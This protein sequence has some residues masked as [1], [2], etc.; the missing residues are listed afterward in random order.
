MVITAD[1]SS[2]LLRI[3]GF[4]VLRQGQYISL[5]G[6]EFV[7]A[8]V[9]SGVRYLTT[10]VML[11]LLF[12]YLSFQSTLKRL[13]FVFLTGV[14]LIIANG[15]RAYLIMA[16][17]STTE[18]QYLGG[19]DHIY[20]GWALFGIV[21]MLIMWIGS[22]YADVA[23]EVIADNA[24]DDTE[25]WSQSRLPLI[26]A[27]GSIM[28]A[29]TIRPLRADLGKA[30]MFVMLA[31]V[32]LG[33]VILARWWRSGSAVETVSGS[34]AEARQFNWR[35]IGTGLTTISLLLIAPVS[36][37]LIEENAS[38]VVAPPR[39][40]SLADCTDTKPWQ[41][42]WIPEMADPDYQT[43]LTFVCLDQ[44]VSVFIA[45][46]TSLLSG[47]QLV[48]SSNRMLPS[49]WDRYTEISKARSVTRDERLKNVK[50]AVIDGPD[51]HA[52]VWYWYQID[53]QVAAAPIAAKT[54]QV[55]TLLRGRPA[56]GRVLVLET[57]VFD[58]LDMA[59][60]RLENAASALIGQASTA[61]SESRR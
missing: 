23:R 2:T 56:G 60:Q 12:S 10:G 36:L 32:I 28:L 20:F 7:V 21:M 44:P 19:R 31:V 26:V 40:E 14:S 11:A 53:G 54:M 35:A 47:R 48:N 55:I 15:I 9:C 58:N 1:V 27:L 16:I 33:G 61:K 24:N 29:V 17:A 4:P 46:Y 37:A 51:Y 50:E 22:N 39:L 34:R 30:G 49:N 57:P 5:P 45:G 59:R 52:L 42:R 3:S 8:D 43:S 38:H 6:G 41:T 13:A 18:F 25:S